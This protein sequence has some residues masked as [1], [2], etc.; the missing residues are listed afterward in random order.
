M[1]CVHH[2]PD[3]GAEQVKSGASN[4][5]P[6]LLRNRGGRVGEGACRV[7]LNDQWPIKAQVSRAKDE[8]DSVVIG[9]LGFCWPLGLRHSPE[10]A[11]SVA[12]PRRTGRGDHSC[13]S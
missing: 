5:F 13:A 6:P 9:A 8:R 2:W 4:V 3:D 12:L 11:P 1:L 7:M 10:T